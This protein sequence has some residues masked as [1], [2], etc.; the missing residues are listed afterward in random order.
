LDQCVRPLFLLIFS[1][2]ACLGQWFKLDAVFVPCSFI[3]LVA[4]LFFVFLLLVF[5][6]D[7]L[8]IPALIYVGFYTG[9]FF[10]HYFFSRD[11]FPFESPPPLFN[12]P[13]FDVMFCD[14]C[15]SFYLHFYWVLIVWRTLPRPSA[16]PAFQ[17]INVLEPAATARFPLQGV[18]KDEF[19]HLESRGFEHFV[20]PPVIMLASPACAPQFSVFTVHSALKSHQ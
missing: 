20:F 10:P 4:S 12:G 19:S 2:T 9:C 18:E 7:Q 11:V 6:W 13:P 14:F 3:L 17:L 8:Q 5:V 15:M 1:F 16:V